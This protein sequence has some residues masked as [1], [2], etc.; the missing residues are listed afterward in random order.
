MR[1]KPILEIVNVRKYF[2]SSRGFI[3]TKLRIV[4]AV[5]NVSFTVPRSSFYSIV[6]ESGSGKTTLGKV[7]VR[8]C[9]PESGKVLVNGIDISSLDGS[10]LKQVRRKVT[11]IFQDP[12]SSLNPRRTV[13]DIVME[14]LNIHKLYD[15]STRLKKVKEFLELVG[16]SENYLYSRPYE[17]SGGQKQRVALARAL[18]VYPSLVIL[19]EPTSALDVSVQAKI[20][21]LLKSLQMRFQ[22]SYLLITHDLSVVRNIAEFVLVMYQGKIVE[23]ASIDE[24]FRNPLHPYTVSLLSSIPTIFDE[25]LRYLPEKVALKGEIPSPFDPHKGC[26]FNSRCPKKIGHI[27]EE[28][29]PPTLEICKGHFVSCHL[30]AKS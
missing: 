24:L 27:C 26:V 3:K 5:D 10:K 9:R 7:I 2:Y 15:R 12:A 17:L 8:L 18:V 19:D 29:E 1:Q 23:T 30:F 4:K 20:L 11:M 21:N 25:E 13:K 28:K 14:P 16:L 6:G 22:L